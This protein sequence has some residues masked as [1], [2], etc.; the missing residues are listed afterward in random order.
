MATILM[1]ED[2]LNFVRLLEKVLGAHGHTIIH[3]DT[4]LGGLH[5]T[6]GDTA[7][8][9]VLLDMDL[10]DLDGKVVA[11]TLRTRPGMRKVPIIAVTAQND[12]ITRRLVLAFGCNAFI[13]KP[14]DT[15]AFP[16]QIA[17]FLPAD[18]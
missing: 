11:T 14:I 3:A 17:A 1:I 9:L 5:M 2:D 7:F 13:P 4:A 16:N 6:E 12:A 15:R 8:D 18:E 10:P